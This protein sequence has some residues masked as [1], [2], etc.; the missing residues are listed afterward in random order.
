MPVGTLRRVL[1]YM[2]FCGMK[3]LIPI[4]GLLM[5]A[6]C[7][8]PSGVDVRDT[9]DN[10]TENTVCQKDYHMEP[11]IYDTI[12]GHFITPRH[13]DTLITINREDYEFA[14]KHLHPKHKIYY[15]PGVGIELNVWKDEKHNI[16]GTLGFQENDF[17]VLVVGRLEKNKNCVTIIDAVS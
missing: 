13:T 8:Q 2:Y 16:R 15:V 9:T 11:V 4:V 3:Q 14:L 12:F 10:I 1:F 6:S 5:L 7:H 17:L